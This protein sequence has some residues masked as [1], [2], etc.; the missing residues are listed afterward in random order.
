MSHRLCAAITTVVINVMLSSST[1][2][3]PPH[4]PV[5]SLIA[6]FHTTH[7]QP[8]R[9]YT[10]KHIATVFSYIFERCTYQTLFLTYRDMFSFSCLCLIYI[11]KSFKHKILR[12]VRVI[13]CELNWKYAENILQPHA[14]LKLWCWWWWWRWWWLFVSPIERKITK[15]IFF[16]ELIEYFVGS[17]RERSV[18]GES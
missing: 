1:S 4:Y 16:I 17:G 12:F 8:R 9:V 5:Y 7:I 11:C 3:H 6:S 14:R 18:F 2:S 10:G 15:C 13:G